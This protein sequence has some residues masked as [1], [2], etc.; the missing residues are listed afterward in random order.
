MSGLLLFVTQV[1]IVYFLNHLLN[2]ALFTQKLAIH[3]FLEFT[4]R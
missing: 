4:E 2:F 1:V 3:A